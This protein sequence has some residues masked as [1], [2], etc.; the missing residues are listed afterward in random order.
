MQKTGEQRVQQ[1]K[2]VRERRYLC[3]IWWELPSCHGL[4]IEQVLF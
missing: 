2:R 3:S 4:Q 1:T